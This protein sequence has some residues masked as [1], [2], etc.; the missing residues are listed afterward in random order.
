MYTDAFPLFLGWYP[1]SP[2]VHV[3]SDG[4][5][6]FALRKELGEAT[7]RLMI[8]GGHNREIVLLTPQETITFSEIVDLINEATGRQVQFKV[9]ST[10][11]FLAA[12]AADEG[13]KG[14]GFFR[15]IITWYDSIAKGECGIT[16][17]LMADLLGREPVSP[18]E[19]IR[20]MLQEN[21]SYAWHQNYAK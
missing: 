9:V 10:D 11:E 14:E 19:A 17:P 16:D 21:P 13:G 20:A 8:R 15:S 4:P 2:T 7:A 5:I 6:A 18:R 1:N 12:K 3:T